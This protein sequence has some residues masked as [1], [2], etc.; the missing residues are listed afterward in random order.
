MALP[1]SL[2]AVVDEMDVMSEEWVA[3]INR[4]TGQL[5][6]IT[7]YDREASTEALQAEDS[8][9]FI[10]VPSKFDIHEYSIMERFSEAIAEPRLREDLLAAIRGAGAFRRFK[11]TIRRSAVEDDWYSFRQQSLESIAASFL[12]AHGIPYERG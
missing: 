7:D 10:A 2:Q 12:D 8:P 9:D 4:R 11:D 5:V 1:V 6:T 3:Y